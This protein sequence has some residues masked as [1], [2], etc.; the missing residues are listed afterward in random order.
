MN[1]YL[2]II[3]SLIH[4]IVYKNTAQIQNFHH[5]PAESE[6]KKMPSDFYRK[7]FDFMN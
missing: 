2:Q 1:K 3:I 5:F 4:R 6:I 7:A